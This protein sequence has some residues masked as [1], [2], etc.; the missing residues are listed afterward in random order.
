M[1][2]VI[3]V[4]AMFVFACA[5]GALTRRFRRRRVPVVTTEG[6]FRCRV[7]ASGAGDGTRTWTRRSIDARWVH[8]VL[9]LDWGI[10]RRTRRALGVRTAFGVLEG[11]RTLTSDDGEVS[12]CFELDDG[13]TICVTTSEA[14]AEALGGPFLCAHPAVRRTPPR[15]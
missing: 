9:V 7:R 2:A 11:T 15:V 3:A 1:D 13:S 4:L 12:L 8:D 10:I 14:A 5:V 6:V